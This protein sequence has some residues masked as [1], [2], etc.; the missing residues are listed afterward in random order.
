MS[1]MLVSPQNHPSTIMNTSTT[2]DFSPPK[3]TTSSEGLALLT[4]SPNLVTLFVS[5]WTN[6]STKPTLPPIT[7]MISAGRP[8][9]ILI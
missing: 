9:M 1:A 3:Y 6:I 7:S 2:E 5:R 4:T 8:G